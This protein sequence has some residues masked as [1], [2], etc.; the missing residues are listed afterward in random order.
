MLYFTQK[1]YEEAELLFREAVK[2]EPRGIDVFQSLAETLLLRQKYSEA[3]ALLK[4]LLQENPQ[5]EFVLLLAQLYGL[6]K[7]WEP[8]ELLL[9]YSGNDGRIHA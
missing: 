3:E 1:K 2:L 9:E 5:V 8:A 6:Q 7:N 4:Q